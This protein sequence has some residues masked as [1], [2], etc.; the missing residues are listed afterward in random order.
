MRMLGNVETQLVHLQLKP[1]EEKGCNGKKE[2]A[3]FSA[4]CC[5]MKRSLPRNF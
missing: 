3:W 1:D 4:V 5:D 2:V